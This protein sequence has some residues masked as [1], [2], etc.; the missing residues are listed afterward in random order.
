MQ[1]IS[2]YIH[3]KFEFWCPFSVGYSH[4]LLD[5]HKRGRGENQFLNLV[6]KEEIGPVEGSKMWGVQGNTNTFEGIS[7][8][9]DTKYQ[10]LEEGDIPP[11]V[12]SGSTAPEKSRP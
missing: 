7:F 4:W 12:P 6:H 8:A 11:P 9:F 2:S 5:L 10:N 1:C 3:H